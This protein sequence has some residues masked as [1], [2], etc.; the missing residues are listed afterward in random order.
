MGVNLRQIAGINSI[1]DGRGADLLDSSSVE[2]LV[3][4]LQFPWKLQAR[5]KIE[6]M[7]CDVMG[8]KLS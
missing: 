7:L 8:L 5:E 4:G 1:K 2:N 6:K 3:W